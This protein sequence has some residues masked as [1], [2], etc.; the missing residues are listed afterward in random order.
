M[1]LVRRALARRG[2]NGAPGGS[3][4]RDGLETARQGADHGAVLCQQLG[5]CRAR[6]EVGLHALPLWP[7]E[8]LEGVGSQVLQQALVLVN[9]GDVKPPLPP[10]ARAGA[11]A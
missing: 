8:R 6:A 4:W 2:S 7:L 5:T 1:S 11:I 10:P 3:W 9:H